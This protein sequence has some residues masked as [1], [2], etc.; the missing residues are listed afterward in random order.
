MR[1]HCFFPLLPLLFVNC[2]DATPLLFSIA[3]SDLTGN[4]KNDL[5]VLVHDRVRVYPQE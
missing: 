3:F 4:G 1:P 2:L 5:A